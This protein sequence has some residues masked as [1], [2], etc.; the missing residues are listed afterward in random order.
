MS[1]KKQPEKPGT[2]DLW[3]SVCVTPP[4]ITKHVKR[5]GGFTAVCAQAQRKN[6]TELWGPYGKDWGMKN[7][8]A[9]L[10]GEQITAG[11][12]IALVMKGTFFFPEGEFDVFGDHAWEVGDDVYKKLLTDITTKAL[13]MLGF[14]ADVFLGLYDDNKYVAEQRKKSNEKKK[15]EK[16]PNSATNKDATEDLSER[17]N[18]C[19]GWKALEN[20]AAEIKAA[21]KEGKLTKTT[22]GALKMCLAA[23]Q[24]KFI[25]EQLPKA[26]IMK[27]AE[28][29]ADRS[30][31][32]S[33]ITDDDKK[34]IGQL[35]VAAKN[36]IEAASE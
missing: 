12:P 27:R 3:N 28:L 7:V 8:T 29:L 1:D 15:D 4:E 30:R 18:L 5:R 33:I 24:A 31:D 13:S 6:A 10:I 17:I 14:N 11:N 21:A 36:R 22:L 35:F 26:K 20:I 32:S 9:Q 2:L 19:R 23:S 16:A 25:K 34:E